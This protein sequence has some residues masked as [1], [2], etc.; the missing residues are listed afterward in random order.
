MGLLVGSGK[1]PFQGRLVLALKVGA[2]EKTRLK[3]LGV[4]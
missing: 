3:P 2:R 4:S 1:S